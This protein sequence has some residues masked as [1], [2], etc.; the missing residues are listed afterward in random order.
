M[1]KTIKSPQEKKGYRLLVAAQWPD[2]FPA[3]YADGFNPKLAP[4]Q[5]LYDALIGGR[6]GFEEFEKRYRQE[7]EGQK[8]R[9]QSICKQAEKFDIILITYEDFQG[10]SIG[11]I[12]FEEIQKLRKI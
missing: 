8:E 3:S 7:L 4:S 11:K 6:I 10:H 12:L 5:K 2:F 1:L 9:M